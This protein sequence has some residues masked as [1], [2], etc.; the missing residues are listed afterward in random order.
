MK[1]WEEELQQNIESGQSTDN[2]PDAQAYR[3]VFDALQK[4]PQYALPA[5]F[6]RRVM[7][8]IEIREK[9]RLSFRERRAVALAVFLMVIALA[10]TI[11]M[12]GVKPALGVLNGVSPHWAFIVFAISFIGFLHWLDRRFI[13][14]KPTAK[15]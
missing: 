11:Y 1:N 15:S 8:K 4:E 10:V 14:G 3:T 6:A 2:G 13:A 7:Q 9:R 12:T 5:G